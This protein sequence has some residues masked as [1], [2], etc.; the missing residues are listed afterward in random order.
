MKAIEDQSEYNLLARLHRRSQRKQDGPPKRTRVKTIVFICLAAFYGLGLL[1]WPMMSFAA[2]FVFDNPSNMAL[3]YYI[4]YSI[5]LYP[6]FW[7]CGLILGWLSARRGWHIIVVVL[8]TSIPML[9]AMRYILTPL[10]V[11]MLYN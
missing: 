7:I 8:F 3:A 1:E 10:L 6:C 9:S 4:A 11:A 5:W 2:I